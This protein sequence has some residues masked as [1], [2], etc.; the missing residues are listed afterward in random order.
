DAKPSYFGSG[1]PKR[2]RSFGFSVMD[3]LRFERS[4]TCTT[5]IVRMPRRG[6]RDSRPRSLRPAADGHGYR[7]SLTICGLGACGC[8]GIAYNKSPS[9][10][11]ADRS[12]DL[13]VHREIGGPPPPRT[14]PGHWIQQE[15]TACPKRRN[16]GAIS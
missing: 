9:W 14:A 16:R 2:S 13:T 12:R 1:Y 6:V 11:T 4:P 3:A 8:K 7:I 5:A 15:E 10:T